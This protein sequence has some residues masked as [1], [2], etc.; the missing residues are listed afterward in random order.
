MLRL[1][2][3]VSGLAFTLC[4]NSVQ[5]LGKYRQTVTSSTLNWAAADGGS[6]PE[7]AVVAATE[8][9]ESGDSDS[10]KPA[11][12]V[13]VCR[14]RHEGAWI[15]GQLVPKRKVCQVSLLNRVMEYARYEVLQNFEN[16]AKLSWVKWNK[17][18][19]FPKG[20]ISGGNNNFYVARRKAD[21]QE[22]NSLEGHVQGLR[23]TTGLTHFV[24]KINP[25]DGLGKVTV[26]TEVSVTFR[27][28]ME[29]HY[30]MSRD[31]HFSRRRNGNN[32]GRNKT[33]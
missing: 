6:V 8:T 18:H 1:F 31:L 15:P 2:L 17:F 12:N 16:G 22:D 28:E 19:I 14:A 30:G 20:A 9:A 33:K 21:E 7:F 13:Y 10:D 3:L 4:D 25:A 32:K 24:G 27:G 11:V 5:F 23:S 29:L 26:T